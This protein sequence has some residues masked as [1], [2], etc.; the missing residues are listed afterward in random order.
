VL[1]LVVMS[2]TS[3]SGGA[4]AG[5]VGASIAVQVL[6]QLSSVAFY[7]VPGWYLLRARSARV[8][9]PEY[10]ALVAL[11]PDRKRPFSIFL[12]VFLAL[13]AL[14]LVFV[15]GAILLAASM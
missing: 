15:L 9:T 13:L 5:A 1:V 7:A 6:A 8:T 2:A 3:M 14:G 11:E 10:R 4:Q 12:I